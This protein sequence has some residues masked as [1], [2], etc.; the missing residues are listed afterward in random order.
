MAA[1]VFH[2]KDVPDDEADAVRTLLHEAG[3]DCY[4][5]SGGTVALALGL[6]APAIWVR[7]DADKPRARELI[8]AYQAS[9][10][11]LIAGE[12]P[13]TL[14]QRFRDR[15]LPM[16]MALLLIGVVLYFS[17]SPFFF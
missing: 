5:T 8:D 3:I 6:A 7:E 14:A 2:L 4:E 11:G 1:L 17:L 16:L 15:P 12:P 10:Q 9:R 13:E